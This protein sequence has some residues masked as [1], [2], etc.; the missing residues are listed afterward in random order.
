M[1][2]LQEFNKFRRVSWKSDKTNLSNKLQAPSINMLILLLFMRSTI[3][4]LTYSKC[5]DEIKLVKD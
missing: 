4:Y 5:S 2:V 1:P 3:L